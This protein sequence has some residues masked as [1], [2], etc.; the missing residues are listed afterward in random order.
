MPYRQSSCPTTAVRH[1]KRPLLPISFPTVW[2]DKVF[3]SI[4]TTLVPLHGSRCEVNALVKSVLE[5]WNNGH[6]D[7][8]ISK[9][10]KELQKVLVLV[11]EGEGTNNLVEK[12]RGKK[13]KNLTLPA[14][15]NDAEDSEINSRSADGR[16]IP[17][18][19]PIDL[20]HEIDDDDDEHV[21]CDV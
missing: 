21:A 8:T 4:R 16:F 1:F 5:T 17:P 2:D 20:S 6:L 15:A 13:Y 11:V 14:A 18:P 3:V 19:P 7:G 12:K 9:V 10:F